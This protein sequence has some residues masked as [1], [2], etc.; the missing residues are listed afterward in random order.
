[1]HF[2]S[3]KNPKKTD[4]C[5]GFSFVHP[6]ILSEIISGNFKKLPCT[7]FLT[8]K[9]GQ[10]LLLF[11]EF[12]YMKKK[13]KK[14][15]SPATH[16]RKFILDPTAEFLSFCLKIFLLLLIEGFSVCFIKKIFFS[17]PLAHISWN[18]YFLFFF[19]LYFILLFFKDLC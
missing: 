2:K 15:K 10:V 8:C 7:D 14:E 12:F 17:F 6:F 5:K 9:I 4:I 13:K 11:Y 18:Y 3:E 16:P 19:L 1:M